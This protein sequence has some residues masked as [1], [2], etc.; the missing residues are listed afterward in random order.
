[1]LCRACLRALITKD[2]IN[3][4]SRIVIMLKVDDPINNIVIIQCNKMR[5][6]IN[7]LQI[8]RYACFVGSDI[9]IFLVL[10]TYIP[11]ASGKAILYKKLFS[12]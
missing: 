4:N 8:E 12:L 10:H 5:Y 11:K 9:I 6:L 3:L 1:M 2:L 7:C